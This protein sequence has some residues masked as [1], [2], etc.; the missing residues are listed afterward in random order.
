MNPVY[1]I[2]HNGSSCGYAPDE[3]EAKERVDTMVDGIVKEIDG[4]PDMNAYVTRKDDEVIVYVKQLGRVWDGDLL[5]HAVVSYYKVDPIKEVSEFAM[6]AGYS[7]SDSSSE[8]TTQ[9]GNE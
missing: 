1:V 9:S 4:K 8:G 3:K 5:S 6:A 2:T 7:V